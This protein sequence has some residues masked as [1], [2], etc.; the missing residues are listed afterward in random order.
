MANDEAKEFRA[1]AL[2]ALNEIKGMVSEARTILQELKATKAEADDE[3][4]D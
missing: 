4:D 1:A 3:D 2:A